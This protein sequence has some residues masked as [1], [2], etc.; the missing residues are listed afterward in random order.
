MSPRC[1][2]ADVDLLTEKNRPIRLRLANSDHVSDDLLLVKQ[3]SGSET[4]FGGIDY[5]LLCVSAKA[6]LPLKHFIA[7]PAELQFVTDSGGLRSVCGIVVSAVE[8]QS[9][10][11]LASYQLI[12]RDAFSL[13][14]KNCNTRVFRQMSEVDITN[15]VLKEWRLANPVAARAFDFDLG[16]LRSYPA[17]EFTMQYN[18]SSRAFLQRLWKRRGIAWFI[19]P[20]A[21][22]ESGSDDTPVHSLVLF[23]DPACLKANAAGTI[24]YH[25][26]DGTETR[27]VITAWHAAR[28]LTAGR[29]TRRSWDYVQAW[30]MSSHESSLNDQGSLGNQF[31][32]ALDDYYIDT[33][34]AGDDGRDYRSHGQLRMQRHEY[35]SKAFQGEGS[36]R[37]M[38]V[39]EWNAISGHHELDTHPESEREFVITELRIEAENNL[40]GALDERIR[41]LFALN[42]WRSDS[43]GLARASAER[44]VRYINRFTCVRRGLPIV[45]SYDP[46]VD[47][48]RTEA[49]S[50]I[51][52]GP[53]NE[54]VHCDAMGRVKVRFPACRVEDHDHAQGAGAS[55]SDRDSAWVRVAS[56]WASTQYGAI[57]LPRAGDEVICVFLRGDPDKPLIMGRVHGG[58][59]PPPS[60]S[61]VSRLPGDRYLSGIKSKEIGAARYNQL[62]MDDTPGQISAQLESEHGHSQLNVGYLTHPRCDGKAI[63][64]GEGFELATNDSGAIRTAKSLLLTAWKRLDACGNQLSGEEH[65]ALMQDC[66]D[67]FKSLGQY[68]AQH[69]AM[70]SDPEPQQALQCDVAQ[71][72]GGSNVDSKAPGGQPTLSATAPAAPHL[73]YAEDCCHLCRCQ[74]RHRR[75][76][77]SAND[78]RSTLQSECRERNLALFPPRRYQGDCTPGQ[79]PDPKPAR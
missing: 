45:P 78:Q 60:F 4:M 7:N 30:S 49:Q 52:V 33:P 9:D 72:A 19:R 34:H 38:C 17:R 51:V 76:A 54:E 56:G 36:D 28:H 21:A 79:V 37:Q 35:A 66:L 42:H 50:V 2:P 22:T 55:D 48:P 63:A 20:G 26:D 62:R 27:D 24:R 71:A 67:L 6:G 18:E 39:G 44:G 64:R 61:H 59:T 16:H 57:S 43:G 41:R 31:A 46:R 14:D 8:G 25:R 15:I 5:S 75:P 12:I 69:Q 32:A 1:S 58:K 11:G 47:L 53:E 29:V 40:P 23:D 70:P 13:L 73:Q 65:V 10:G 74:H 68:A 3:V 77:A